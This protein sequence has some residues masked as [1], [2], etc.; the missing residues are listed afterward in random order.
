M[1]FKDIEK[2]LYDQFGFEDV[3]Q[4]KVLASNFI[5]IYAASDET[6]FQLD[7]DVHQLSESLEKTGYEI[8]ECDIIEVENHAAPYYKVVF[9]KDDQEDLNDW[10]DENGCQGDYEE[11]V[12]QERWF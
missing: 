9:R 3:Q 6:E 7:L 11:A 4:E 8:D 12:H 5:I 1:K 2:K 10:I